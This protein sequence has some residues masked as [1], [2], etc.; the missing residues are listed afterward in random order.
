[1]GQLETAYFL[2]VPSGEDVY[3]LELTYLGAG[4]AAL[5]TVTGT[6]AFVKSAALGPSVEGIAVDA[7]ETKPWNRTAR[8]G[9]ADERVVFGYDADW[10]DGETDAHVALAGQKGGKTFTGEYVNQNGAKSTYTEV[11]CEVLELITPKG[12][13][14]GQQQVMP[15][16][17]FVPQG[18]PQYQQTPQYQQQ[19]LPPA[20][21]QFP[22]AQAPVGVFGQPAQAA[23][24][25]PQWP[26]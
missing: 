23:P 11:R 17:G 19:Q 25:A 8:P 24:A 26:G 7:S 9:A 5:E 16:Q 13:S 21:Q 4:G 14:Q 12:Q 22:Q 1:M 6:V 18:A 2:T 3:T 15:Q 20:P 10:I